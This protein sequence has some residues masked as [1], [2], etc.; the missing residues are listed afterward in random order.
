MQPALPACMRLDVLWRS[1]VVARVPLIRAIDKRA[2]VDRQGLLAHDQAA[3]RPTSPD[4]A[5]TAKPSP[6][7]SD[8]WTFLA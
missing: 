4:R 1:R 3:S 6:V 8:R 5:G 2:I 7:Q